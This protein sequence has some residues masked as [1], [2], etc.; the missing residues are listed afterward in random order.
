MLNL[1]RKK[2]DLT[3]FIVD[4]KVEAVARLIDIEPQSVDI[5]IHQ[6]GEESIIRTIPRGGRTIL[7]VG[8]YQVRVGFRELDQYDR[9]RVKIG[10][11]A[12]SDV[13]IHRESVYLKAVKAGR[14]RQTMLDAE[15]A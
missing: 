2:G 15:F 1:W 14:V 5:E 7:R 6:Q 10:F 9:N 13:T 12:S 8:V 11:D 3:Y 4:Q